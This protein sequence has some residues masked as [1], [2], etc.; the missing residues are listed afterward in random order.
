MREEG[1]EVKITHK[2]CLRC[3]RMLHCAASRARGYGW[4]CWARIRGAR[5]LAALVQFTR[6]QVDQ[7]VELIEDAAVIP[8]AIATVFRTVSSDGQRIYLMT[9]NA[10]TCPASG[11]CFHRA[12]VLMVTA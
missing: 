8:T 10:C 11:L 12:G 1:P 6:R 9:V 3:G 5:K 2:H 4:G 7:A